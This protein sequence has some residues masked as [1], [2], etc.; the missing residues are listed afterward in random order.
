MTLWEIGYL[1][2]KGRLKLKAELS[3]FW[4]EAQERLGASEV[5]VS[6]DDVMKYHSLPED[7]HGDP[8]DRFLVAQA[9]TRGYRFMTAD[10]KILAL[11]EH[12]VPAA[13][14]SALSNL[15][16]EAQE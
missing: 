5:L 15:S 4:H 12:L 1:V 10:Q 13:I 14:E 16:N 6:A 11:R 8:G 7:F 9:M 3:T 2:G